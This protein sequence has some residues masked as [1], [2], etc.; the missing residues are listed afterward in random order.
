MGIKIKTNETIADLLNNWKNQMLKV[1]HEY[2]RSLAW[3]DPQK[4]FFIDSIFRNY[5]VPAFYFHKKIFEHTDGENT[6]LWIVDG[7]QRINA[8]Y[9]FVEGEFALLNP[10]DLKI[11]N[12]I[13]DEESPWAGKRFKQLTEEEQ[14]KFLTTKIVIYE[15]TTENENEIRDLFIRLQGGVTL[16]AQDKR[17]SWPGKFTEFVLTAGGKHEV[18]KWYGWDFF[19][20][21]AK[22]P[23]ESKR[24][25]LVAQCYMLFQKKRDEGKFTD[26]NLNSIDTY[27]HTNVDFDINSNNA[28]RFETICDRLYGIFKDNHP[29]ISPIHYV[30]HLILFMDYILDKAVSA[31]FVEIPKALQK[32]KERDQEAKN[33]FKNDEKSE[34]EDYF[35]NYGHYT[36]ASS[37]TAN[38]IEI[39]HNFFVKEM[40]KLTGITYKDSKRS[41]SETDRASVYYRDKKKCQYCRMNG[42]DE[43]VRF[44]DAHFHHIK[45]YNEG[46]KTTVDNLVTV[47]EKC[48]PQAS[49]D[50]IRFREWWE[51]NKTKKDGDDTKKN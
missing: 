39:R 8:I 45:P 14:E 47:H 6:A 21:I 22:I 12:F 9:K 34:H 26:I 16:S 33:A 17:D 25:T 11:P 5:P 31:D 24:R 44:S 32:F 30:I 51:K 50:V 29:K 1:D 18:A 19:K 10:N 28:K 43:V 7:Q 13:K 4:Q 46:G 48:H 15:I 23:N 49:D 38:S 36:I 20:K 35:K 37:D 40:E 27:Y 42:N 3:S 41:L 2:Q